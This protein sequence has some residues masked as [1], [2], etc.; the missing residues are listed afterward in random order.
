M[1]NTS[2][3]PAFSNDEA[4]RIVRDLYGI[5]G[6][7]KSLD[8]ERDLNYLV[9]GDSGRFVFKIAHRDETYGM[10]ECQ[11]H[12]LKRLAVDQV[13]PGSTSSVESLDARV[14]EVITSAAGINHYCRILH[15]VEGRLLSGVSP[16]TPELLKDLGGILARIDNSLQDFSHEVLGR[17]FIW[18]MVDALATLERFKSL[19]ETDRQRELVDSFENLFRDNVL[20]SDERLRRAVIHNDANDN[21]VLVAGDEPGDLTISSIIDF[22]DMVYSWLAV[23]PAVAAAYAMMGKE[24]PLEAATAIIQGYHESLPLRESEIKV[25]FSLICMRLCMSVCICAHQKSIVPDNGYLKI[26]EKPA[27]ELLDKL[28]NVSSETASQMFLEA[29]DMKP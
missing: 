16:H 14:I 18:N 19:L 24:H 12:A 4:S 15:Y 10:L 1:T 28:A 9:T 26:S 3:L 11:H 27:W 25:E 29:C 22:G 8:G 6:R 2:V 21:N 23:E 13:M 20:G 7:I 17:P 5:E